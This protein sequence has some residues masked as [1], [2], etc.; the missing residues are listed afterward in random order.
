M[1]R[2]RNRAN[3]DPDTI[4]S[5][6]RP[7]QKTSQFRSLNLHQ[8]NFD[9]PHKHQINSTPTLKTS[10]APSPTLKASQFWPP[11]QKPGQ[12]IPTRKKVIFG[13]HTKELNFDPRTKNKSSLVATIKPSQFGPSIQKPRDL[14]SN[15]D[16]KS[17]PMHTVKTSQFRWSSTH[18]KK[19][20]QD[21]TEGIFDA[22]TK[23]SQFRSVTLKSSL[24]WRPTQ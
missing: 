8:V 3:F 23:K 1:P 12:W 7:S 21:L 9:H 13:P 6:F 11:T 15:P 19:S 14:D 5:H 10:Q 24:F 4:K 16:V 17:I 22:H 2:Y 18:T 20:I